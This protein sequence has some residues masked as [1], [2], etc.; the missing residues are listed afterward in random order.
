MKVLAWITPDTWRS[1]VDAVRE[2]TG[3]GDVVTLVALVDE[4]VVGAGGGAA[5]GL[6]G[7]GRDTAEQLAA[8]WEHDARALLAEAGSALGGAATEV[9]RGRP[10]RVLVEMSAGVDLLVLVRDG[11]LRPGPHSLDRVGRFVVDHVTCPLLLLPQPDA[12]PPT[13][14][15]E[16]PAGRTLRPGPGR[17]RRPSG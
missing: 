14:P 13:T 2:R 1:C 8:L 3:P 15:P 11:D 17:L 10:E 5:A 12:G 4:E 6:L 16:P 9:R 7:R